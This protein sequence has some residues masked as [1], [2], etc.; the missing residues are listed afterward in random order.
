MTGPLS[1][2]A[3]HRGKVGT[4]ILTRIEN[5]TDL[6]LAYTPGVA[7]VCNELSERPA[8]AYQYTQKGRTVAVI[9]DGSAV[10]GLGNIGAL[11]SL[12]VMEGKAA[13]FKAL[14]DLDAVALPVDEQEPEA[15][16]DTV[17]RLAPAF[18]AINLE[19]IAAPKCFVIEKTLKERLN[20]PVFH[21]D[22]HGT[23]VVILAALQNALNLRKTPLETVKIVVSGAGAAGTATTKLLLAQ[24]ATRVTVVDSTGVLSLDR[25]LPAHKQ[26]LA[27]LIQASCGTLQEA[28]VGADV[29][30]G[31]SAKDVLSQQDVER[32]NNDAVVFALAN[33]DPEILPEAAKK[34][35]AA[36]I[37]TGRSDYPN[38]INN[39][40]AFPGML[41]GA[42]NAAATT[43]T[44]DM[45]LAAS[46]AIAS[47]VEPTAEKLLPDALDRAVAENVASAVARTARTQGVSRHS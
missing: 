25:D 41:K 32:M 15:F 16:I 40:L 28:I 7:V 45:Q 21:D 14:A 5:A 12:P 13:L 19:D 31:V 20:I 26:E 43:I 34:G 3:T 36:Y 29:F 27:T 22:Q 9:S 33:P 10:L 39:V 18:G 1:Y 42:I 23:A 4:R 47:S 8:Q 24:G 17:E 2:H 38:Q 46:N 37:A 6:S 11:A 44:H 30:I 35:G